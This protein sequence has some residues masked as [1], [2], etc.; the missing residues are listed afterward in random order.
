MNNCKTFAHSLIKSIWKIDKTLSDSND[1]HESPK[2]FI[3]SSKKSDFCDRPTALI[4]QLQSQL[5]ACRL[6]WCHEPVLPWVGFCH[7]NLSKITIMHRKHKKER[8][9]WF[10]TL[11]SCEI[12]GTETILAANWAMSYSSLSPVIVPCSIRR[13]SSLPLPL[14]RTN[15]LADVFATFTLTCYVR[16]QN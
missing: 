13:I 4:W 6:R 9:S 10:I 15:S 1:K 7:K 12:R 3:T 16:V 2:L 14:P 8:Y 11:S 5:D